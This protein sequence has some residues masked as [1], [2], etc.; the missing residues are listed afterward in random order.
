MATRLLA[1]LIVFCLAFVACSAYYQ[2]YV[3]DDF[4][5]LDIFAVNLDHRLTYILIWYE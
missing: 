1:K 2:T 5:D 3:P 4:L